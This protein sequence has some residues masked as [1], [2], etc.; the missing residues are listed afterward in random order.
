M[1]WSPA[2]SPALERWGALTTKILFL[3]R[4]TVLR[5]AYYTLLACCTKLLR[6]HV[7][8]LGNLYAALAAKLGEAAAQA[9]FERLLL[10]VA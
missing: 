8:Y 6:S 9:E 5:L 4:L 2:T 7:A 1:R 10:R 3:E